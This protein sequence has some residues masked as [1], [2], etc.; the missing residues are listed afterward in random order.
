M[1]KS[2]VLLA[3]FVF[4]VGILLVVLL[5]GLV[6]LRTNREELSWWR[7]RAGNTEN[8]YANY[9]RSQPQ[10]R[11]VAEAGTRQDDISWAMAKSTNTLN[12]YWRYAQNHPKGKH[13]D[14]AQAAIAEFMWQQTSNSS[15]PASIEYFL[16]NYGNTAHAADARALVEK[17]KWRQAEKANTIRSL[18]DYLAT[19]PQGRFAAEAKKRQ[20]ALRVAPE[21]FEAARQKQ[22]EKALQEFLIAYPGHSKRMEAEQVL[23]EYTKGW[24]LMES[25]AQKLIAVEAWGSGAQQIR[26]RLRKLTESPLTVRIPVGTY[27]ASDFAS[28]QGMVATSE[29]QLRLT[30][31]DWR[32]VIVSVAAVKPSKD[33]PTENDSFNLER[34]PQKSPLVDLL[35]VLEQA[36]ADFPTRQAAIWIAAANASLGE[37]KSLVTHPSYSLLE[38]IPVIKETDAARALKLCAAAGIDITQKKIWKKSRQQILDRVTDPELKRWM[39]E[40][41]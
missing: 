17:L 20:G 1:K 18:A 19:Y 15:S 3:L 10:G 2:K 22:T 4:L 31:N 12:G 41:P 27:F 23:D 7:A 39:E 26:V 37:L 11:H 30:A 13:Y 36:G 8:S 5:A 38:D 14:E 6:L 25:R 34:L 40:Q 35:P 21:P 28:V 16:K 33:I 9:L 29:S 24:D 32:F